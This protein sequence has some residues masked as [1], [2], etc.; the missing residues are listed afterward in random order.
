M[1]TQGDKFTKVATYI[2]RRFRVPKTTV[3]SGG[4]D[5]WIAETLWSAMMYP[6]ASV[7]QRIHTTRLTHPHPWRG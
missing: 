5:N 6:R 4:P 1:L 3:R 2:T 7:T